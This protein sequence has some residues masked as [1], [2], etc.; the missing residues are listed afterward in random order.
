MRNDEIS[1]YTDYGIW[2]AVIDFLGTETYVNYCTNQSLNYSNWASNQPSKNDSRCVILSTDNKWH[3]TFCNKSNHVLCEKTYDL[4]TTTS[5][6]TISTTSNKTLQTT[7]TILSTTEYS[8]NET[9]TTK[10][11]EITPNITIP[12]TYSATSIQSIS[13]ASGSVSITNAIENANTTNTIG[14]SSTKNY[15][16]ISSTGNIVR[17]TKTEIGVWT[18]WY[19]T[20]SILRKVKYN[21]DKTINK[22]VYQNITDIGLCDRV[23]ANFTD[24][25]AKKT[26][27]ESKFRKT[28]ESF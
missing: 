17:L 27:S 6:S 26:L 3:Y 24:G 19:T 2:L 11:G 28:I 13:N 4:V 21:F 25:K 1:N 18:E 14:S 8:N 9:I 16:T 22:T 23:D 12:T 7:T 15:Q 10:Y 5:K 20:N